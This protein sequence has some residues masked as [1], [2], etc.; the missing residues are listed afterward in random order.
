[1]LAGLLAI[2]M[3]CGLPGDAS[4]QPA[5][6][7]ASHRFLI[8]SDIHF[9][10]MSDRSLT[11]DLAAAAPAQW[12]K[13]LE[14]S[15]PAAVSQYGEDTNW[16]LLKSSL[17]AMQ[18]TAPQPSFI[19]ITGDVLAH[20]FP[21]KFQAASGKS[22]REAYRNFVNKTIE[23][24]GL[25]LRH[26][27]P[28]TPIYL[29][30]GNNDED[31]GNYSVQAGGEFLRDTAPIVRELAKGD[32]SLA[33]SW[34]ELGSYEVTP[35][36]LHGTRI[37]SL[38]TVF[39]SDKYQPDNFNAGC[40]QANS[41]GPERAFA[42]LQS[43]LA[44]ARRAHAKVWL[45]FHIP[46]GVDAYMS[47]QNFRRSLEQGGTAQDACGKAAIPM[48][49]PSWTQRFVNLLQEFSDTAVASFAGH[50]HADDFRL[51]HG[52]ASQPGFVLISPAIS[53]IYNQNPAFRVVN[54]DGEGTLTD[55]A[56]YYLTNLTFASRTTPGDWQREYSFSSQWK[57][58][59]IDASS[60]S[61]IL[62]R[63]QK[64]AGVRD[65]YLKL[66]NVTSPAVYVDAKY[67]AALDCAIENLA[68][69][70]FNRC[71]CST[72]EQREKTGKPH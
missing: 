15:Q 4:A 47:A 36:V 41:D 7:E 1:M 10:P 43:R 6:H 11:N 68:P 22:D 55:A 30:P 25:Q 19:M 70:A 34:K 3:V 12:E 13:I 5:R 39:F 23:F 54:V 64:D 45:M 40:A 32:A 71:Y 33:Q 42:W 37:L 46:P 16:W 69:E 72:Y 28:A 66:Y 18:A 60:L 67:G 65:D 48:W 61:E 2:L 9:N 35:A 14:R 63:I 51:V 8:V 52:S 31:C 62:V 59:K 27:F 17:H 44:D 50:T 38:N 21:R 29:T 53:P 58:P 57:L 49:V 20:E 24:L 56:V 26:R